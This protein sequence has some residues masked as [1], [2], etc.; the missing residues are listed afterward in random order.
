[1]CYAEDDIP[2]EH[3][4][5]KAGHRFTELHTMA[6]LA[7]LRVFRALVPQHAEPVGAIGILSCH[8]STWSY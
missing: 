2:V 5:R 6:Y 7:G 3:D 4:C 8:I 1:M